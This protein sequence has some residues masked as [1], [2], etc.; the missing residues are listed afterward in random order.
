MRALKQ[1]KQLVTHRRW[2]VMRKII[3]L[4]LTLLFA[5]IVI[6]LPLIYFAPELAEWVFLLLTL[7]VIPFV[8]GYMF[9]LYRELL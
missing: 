1:A 3:M 7:L 9:A 2:T 4:F 8:H 5:L 6:V